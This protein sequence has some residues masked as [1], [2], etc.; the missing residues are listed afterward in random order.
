[1]KR[2]RSKKSRDTV[3]LNAPKKE[4]SMFYLVN[5]PRGKV[6]SIEFECVLRIT[7]ESEKR[8]ALMIYLS[9]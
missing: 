6:R 7:M 2:T 8:K 1:M 5:E 3:P 9:L 4:L